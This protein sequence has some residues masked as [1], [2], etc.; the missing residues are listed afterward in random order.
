MA[1]RGLDN[2][3]TLNYGEANVTPI[4]SEAHFLLGPE[5]YGADPWDY[6]TDVFYEIRADID[7]LIGDLPFTME[8][9]M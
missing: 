3:P 2:L 9:L 7:D 1:H 6:S 5:F 4:D 8:K